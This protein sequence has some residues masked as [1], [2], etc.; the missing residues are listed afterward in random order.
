MN[1]RESA[2]CTIL[3]FASVVQQQAQ[4]SREM[5]RLPCIM[6]QRLSISGQA[7]TDGNK[8]ETTGNN[9]QANETQAENKQ[10]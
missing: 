10:P 8:R 1:W 9:R 7:I 5:R 4:L 3:H 2:S 6:Q